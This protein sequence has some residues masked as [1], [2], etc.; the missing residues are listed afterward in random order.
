M[1]T[2]TAAAE[3]QAGRLDEALAHA[4]GGSGTAVGQALLGD[5]QEQRG[6]YL[7][8]VKAYQAAVALGPDREQY[9]V[10]LA[11]ELVQHHTFEPAIAVLEQA[12]PHFPKSARLRVLLGVAQF[13]A[14]RYEDAET[15]LTDAPETSGKAV[16][17]VLTVPLKVS[18][19]ATNVVFA[20]STTSSL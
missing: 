14:G 5:I 6:Q 12:A 18:A 8:A 3:L 17:P 15:A 2:A 16:G 20:R 13:A 11:L 7:E 4:Q 10:A 9:R 19:E 1:Q